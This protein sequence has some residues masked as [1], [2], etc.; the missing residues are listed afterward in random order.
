MV[1]VVVVVAA[2]PLASLAADE[3]A[4]S[5]VAPWYVQHC[6]IRTDW[7]NQFLFRFFFRFLSSLC[8]VEIHSQVAFISYAGQ[9]LVIVIVH[10]LRLWLCLSRPHC[11]FR[12]YNRARLIMMMLVLIIMRIAWAVSF[13][14]SGLEYVLQNR[15]R[16]GVGIGIVIYLLLTVLTP[17]AVAVHW[18]NFLVFMCAECAIYVIV[19]INGHLLWHLFLL[20]SGCVNWVAQSVRAANVTVNVIASR[21]WNEG[22]REYGANCVITQLT[23]LLHSPDLINMWV[24]A[25]QLL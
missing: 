9:R 22:G 11:K 2:A 12:H 17:F 4:P 5:R 14:G 8:P 16:V 24:I 20:C 15:S 6:C 7:T 10:R 25:L 19:R 23:Y 1:V 3:A 18:A 21:V 13:L